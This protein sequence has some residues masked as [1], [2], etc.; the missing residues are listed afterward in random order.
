MIERENRD[1]IETIRLAHGK[2][3]ALDL[4]LLDA[5][6]IALAD[7]TRTAR[8]I[9]LTGTGSI[10]CAGVD[11][12]RLI[13]SGPDYVERFL[14][15]LNRA[16]RAVVDLPRP[17]VAAVNGHAIAGGCILA[18]AADYRVMSGGRIG[19]PE[20]LV[21]VPFPPLALEILRNAIPPNHLRRLVMTGA[22][23]T[24][25][26]ALASGV[27]DEISP[28]DTLLQRAVEIAGQLAS[29]PAAAFELTKKQLRAP[30]YELAARSE[31]EWGDSIE[32]E[33]HREETHQGIRDYLERTLRR[34]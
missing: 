19:A 12:P 9:V 2:A 13:S 3:S 10:F 6:E 4:E 5:L 34:K 32:A 25:E 11:L 16:F 29:I 26:E 22:T 15:A 31:R 17:L 30:I 28:P 21:G 33:W 20:L 27:V 23:V 8:A 1:G 24:A 7:A 18:A 14:D